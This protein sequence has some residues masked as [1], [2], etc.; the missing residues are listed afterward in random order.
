MFPTYRCETEVK[1]FWHVWGGDCGGTYTKQHSREGEDSIFTAIISEL[2]SVV[3]TWEGNGLDTA[4]M[5]SPP[6]VPLSLRYVL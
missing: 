5:T 1:M 2:V 3:I 4:I 6:T